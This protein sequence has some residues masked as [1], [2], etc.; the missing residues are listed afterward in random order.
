[1]TRGPPRAF[2]VLGEPVEHSLSPAIHR[3][4][5]R[6]LGLDASYV[7]LEVRRGEVEPVMRAFA[8]RGGGN[9]T[10]PHKLRA[11]SVLDVASPAARRTGA[12]NCF[13]QDSRGRL[14]GDNT[15]VEGFLAALE[16][17]EE[18]P[19][20]D[21]ARVLLLGAGGAAR[22]VAS[23]AMLAN[24]G[25]VEILNR[26]Q[27]H[28]VALARDLDPGGE[29]LRVLGG[30]EEATG[31]YDLVV[32]ATSLGLDTEDPLPLELDGLETGALF[33]LVYGVRETPWIRHGRARGVPATDGKEMLVRQAG[34]S[35][36]RWLD[37]E[38]PLE[39]MR[40]ALRASLT[41]SP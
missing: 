18:A 3:A 1:M 13:W 37:V 39:A 17:W 10:V 22:A 23:A 11:M 24:C 12:C 8:R 7:A 4:A 14:A 41:E 15:D 21:G 40:D 26:T 20:P 2:A 35:L 31:P 16:A 19:A 27:A 29:V 33:D 9:V 25:T 38:A 30:R 28:A 36:E 6:S 34:L 32:N 5:F